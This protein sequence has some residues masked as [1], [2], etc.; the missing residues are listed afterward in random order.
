MKCYIRRVTYCDIFETFVKNIYVIEFE[1]KPYRYNVEN[2][3]FENL[4]LQFTKTN[5]N[6]LFISG[7]LVFL[8][9]TF[10]YK[11]QNL[12]QTQRRKSQNLST[13]VAKTQRAANFTLRVKNLVSL[14]FL[15]K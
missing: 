10:Y 8:V 15:P 5:E 3:W 9:S 1:C 12:I 7:K 14:V 13:G 11:K 6:I 2:S 4:K